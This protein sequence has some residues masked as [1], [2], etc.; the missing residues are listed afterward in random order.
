MDGN[1][2]GAAS[3][4]LSLQRQAKQGR[5]VMTDATRK[6]LFVV[7]SNDRLGDTGR[8]TG[9][10]FEELAT[11]YYALGDG[12]F[13][14]TIAS[15]SGGAAPVDPSSRK[16]RGK[17]TPSVERFLDDPEAIAKIED[18]PAVADLSMD[19]FAALYLPGGHGTMWDLPGCEPLGRLIERA[20]ADDKP[21]ATIC[22]GAA[23]LLAAKRP[24][25]TPLVE[26][27]EINSFT[28]AEE[29]SVGLDGAVPF[30]LESRLREQG[31]RFKAAEKFKA[32]VVT[33]GNLI[34]GQN[35]ASA[36]PL[37]EMLLARLHE[38]LQKAAE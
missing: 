13:D 29:T 4:A 30:L 34:T 20:I 26:G 5:D 14:V 1:G 17:N 9:F 12:G 21:V 2:A 24:D 23:G 6:V 8:K 11:P 37:A 3:P 7:T 16:E 36:Q 27:R 19:D 18:T 22:H 32:I 38:R 28:D 31:A 35:P 33:D 15:V 10:H 25:G